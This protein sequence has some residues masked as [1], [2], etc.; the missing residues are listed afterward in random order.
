V[1]FGTILSAPWNRGRNNGAGEDILG[2]VLVSKGWRGG[3][4]ILA[5]VFRR[6][7]RKR[8]KHQEL[9]YILSGYD[10]IQ[11]C[12]GE[13]VFSLT[14]AG[15]L[16]GRVV[17]LHRLQPTRCSRPSRRFPVTLWGRDHS[18]LCHKTR[19]EDAVI[20][21]CSRLWSCNALTEDTRCDV[22]W[23]S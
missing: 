6:Q 11:S 19:L 21:N 10:W 16:Q 23:Y 18:R 9:T 17:S 3:C 2:C 14:V 7:I 12:D 4:G 20:C 1:D 5:F 13:F 22:T 15:I 8:E